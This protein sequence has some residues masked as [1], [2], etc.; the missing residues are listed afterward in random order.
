MGRI[1]ASAVRVRFLYEP[2]YVVPLGGHLAHEKSCIN[3]F[4]YPNMLEIGSNDS[5]DGITVYVTDYDS[6][7]FS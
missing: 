1:H 2:W 7:S 4:E 3:V 6:S 5:N